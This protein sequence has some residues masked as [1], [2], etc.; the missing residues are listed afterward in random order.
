MN[1]HE[2]QLPEGFE[3]VSGKPFFPTVQYTDMVFGALVRWVGRT[4][5]DSGHVKYEFRSDAGAGEPFSLF[6]CAQLNGKLAN[7]RPNTVLWLK[8][9]GK[10]PQ[11]DDPTRD[12]HGWCVMK[13]KSAAQIA[14]ARTATAQSTARLHKAIAEAVKL[15]DRYRAGTSPAERDAGAPPRDDSGFPPF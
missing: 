4:R 14:E 8:Y 9:E 13:C 5:I 7:F 2:A 12:E 15:Q 10:H 3:E 11:K 6:A 1:E